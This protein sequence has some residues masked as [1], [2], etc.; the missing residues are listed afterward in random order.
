MSNRVDVQVRN[1]NLTEKIKDYV[2]KKAGNLD[3]YLPQIEEAFVELTYHK[4]ARSTADRNVA[5]VTIRGKGLTLRTEERADEILAA[6][7]TAMDNLQRQIE[8]YKGKHYH[9]RGEPQKDDD[10]MLEEPSSFDEDDQTPIIVRRKKFNILPMNEEEAIEEMNLLGHNNF[11]IF[12]NGNT[13][14]INVLYRRRDGSY[15]LIEPELG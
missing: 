10:P 11:F 7:D 13:N 6:F 4:S 5:Q 12:Y 1:L 8:R 15:G 3:H 14:K 2:D 9:N